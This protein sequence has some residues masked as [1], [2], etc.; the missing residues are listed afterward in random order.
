LNSNSLAESARLLQA[1]ARLGEMRERGLSEYVR[2]LEGAFVGQTGEQIVSRLAQEAVDTEL[3]GACLLVKDLSARINDIVHAVG[4]SV[5]LPLILEA[6]E[7]V[8]Y[9]SLA[10][11]NTGKQFDLATDRRVAE[12]KFVNWRGGP[13]SI[14]QNQVFKDHLDLVLYGGDRRKE[15]YLYEPQVALKFF[16]SARSLTSVLSKDAATRNEFY[17]RFNDR[18]MTVNEFFEEHEQVVTFCDINSFLTSA[19]EL[20]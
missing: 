5:L 10:S 17:G 7:R 4:I 11:G 12:F 1:F 18:F 3:L 19:G 13:E 9:V 20:E 8:E 14:R 15:L 6:G 16:H 2:R